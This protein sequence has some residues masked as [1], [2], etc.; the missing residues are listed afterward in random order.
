MLT[1]FRA[2][3]SIH[4]NGVWRRRWWGLLIAWIFCI[5]GWL[6]VSTLPNRYNA[7][8]RVYV[9]T[10]SLLRPLLTGLTV[11]P[12]ID[13]QIAVMQRTLLSRP[14]LEQ[15]ARMTDLDL[16]VNSP[17]E[18]EEMI[19]SL[20]ARIAIRPQALRNFFSISFTDPEPQTAHRVV[21]SLLTLFVETNLGVNRRDMQTAQGFLDT[22]IKEY[23]RRLQEAERRLAEFKQVNI[24]R[25]PQSGS[26][27]A[28]AAALTAQ[29]QQLA[30]DL[31]SA[32]I[33][34][35]NVRR[36][37]ATTP[38]FLQVDTTPQIVIGGTAETNPLLARIQEQER[39]L[40]QLLLRFT[41]QHPDVI[42]TRRIIE[43]LKKQHE[44]EEKVA[45][46]RNA[47]RAAGR[48]VTDNRPRATVPNPL[49]DQL[50]LRLVEEENNVQTMEQR[51]RETDVEVE[52]QRSIA[53]S[54]PEVE[55]EYANL[56]RDYGIIRKNY[57]ELLSRRETSRISQ[58]VDDKRDTVQF[59]VI[60]PPRVP[61]IPSF[62]NR[63]LFMAGVLGVGIVAGIGFALGLSLLSDA[64]PNTARLRQVFNLPVLGS[65]T[66]L[67]SPSERRR[68]LAGTLGFGA[69]CVLLIMAFGG[70]ML[71]LDR[72]PFGLGFALD[73]A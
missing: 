16:L 63:I 48:P 4:L 52:K 32:R 42:A 44:E 64:F 47:D 25:L 73:L 70:M 22:Q 26:F 13:Q 6:V 37:L 9:D 71:L 30:R 1:D 11:S 69:I 45:A 68:R 23:E 35:E 72:M 5:A 8:A 34:R 10:D 41:A 19:T 15:L 28:T 60:D 59:R 14:M 53:R 3:F 55:A 57:E 51:L 7:E 49:Y 38:Q 40:D 62:P 58:A 36:Q 66:A 46:S 54:V 27:A 21:Q 2:L 31:E 29:R 24:D 67:V 65:V 17:I 39:N 61:T 43:Q 12:N 20:T 56:N 50:R 18:R 33:R